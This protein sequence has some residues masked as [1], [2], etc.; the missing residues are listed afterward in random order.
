MAGLG[1][2]GGGGRVREGEDAKSPAGG[3]KSPGGIWGE[4][5]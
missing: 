1:N 4:D 5:E 2:V 3:G